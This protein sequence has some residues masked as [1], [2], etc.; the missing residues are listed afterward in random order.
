MNIVGTVTTVSIR[1]ASISL[2][3]ASGSKRGMITVVSAAS[4]PRSA[5][6]LGAA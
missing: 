2:R 3:N 4:S 6:T 5:K 1:S